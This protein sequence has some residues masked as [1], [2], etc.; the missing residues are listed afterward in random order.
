DGARRMVSLRKGQDANVIALHPL[1]RLS[2]KQSVVPLELE[3][4]K[5]GQTRPADARLFK[6][7]SVSVNGKAVGF[8]REKDFFPPAAFL[9]STDDEKLAAPS[10]E[11]MTAGVRLDAAG[12]LV[13]SIDAGRNEDGKKR[14]ET[15]Q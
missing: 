1:G 11:L 3:I 10:F 2:V 12:Y 7:N 13:K 6:I 9:N 4:S 15:L 14:Y 8:D 5:F